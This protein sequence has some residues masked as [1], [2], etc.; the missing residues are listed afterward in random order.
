MALEDLSKLRIDKAAAA[1]RP[2]QKGRVLR[3]TAAVLAIVFSGYLYSA[4]VLTPS[5]E[6]EAV[7]V[8]QM[9]PSQNFTVLNA[10]G[11]MVAQRKAAVASK[12]TGRLVSLTVEEG[13]R[14]KKGEVIA[15]LES[16][17]LMA[18]RDLAA[19]NLNSSRSA[20]E[21]ATAE[22]GNADISFR[23]SRE[24]VEKG[25]VSR[26]DFDAAQ[27]RLEKTKAAVA[28]AKAAV[29]A[30]TAALKGAEVS[31]EY[32]S[33]RAPFDSVV[34]TKNA[35]IGD[36]VTPLGAAANAKAS[37]VTIADLD[38]LQVEVDVAESNIGL[39]NKGQPCEVQLDSLPDKRFRGEVHMIVPTAD[40][41][42]A[43]VLVKVRILDKDPG[44]LPEMSA[45][46][47][48]L[49]R[50]V[51]QEEK[52]PYTAVNAA[53]IREKAG[54]KFVYLIKSDRAEETMVTVGQK[55]EEMIEVISGVKPGDKVV[56]KPLDRIKP[57][58]RIKLPEG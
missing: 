28:A 35:D 22:L 36:I 21:E 47:A 30:Y 3:W 5:V 55:H 20:L 9:Y 34:L 12:V 8:L 16:E 42:K 58:A 51:G 23:R 18:S 31:L 54:K 6:V 43:T 39:V 7:N 49:S 32:A 56:L 37:V 48:F 53:A 4:G 29:K 40:R 38:S 46:V 33:I 17:D 24:L 15:L 57:G 14:V 26:T 13:V 41:T 27:T 50:P 25:Y 11:Y 10:S 19:A 52:K 2:P 44:I 45:R 1:E